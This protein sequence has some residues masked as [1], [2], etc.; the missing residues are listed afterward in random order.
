MRIIK[1]KE[2][3]LILFL[4]LIINFSTINTFPV[5]DRDE[6][7]YVQSTKQMLETGNYNS[8]KF[9]DDLRSK[10]PIGIYWLQSIS[11]NLFSFKKKT[12]YS[13][14]KLNDIWKYRFI[15]S[16]FSLFSCLAL[17]FLATKVFD[18]KTAF[19]SSLTLQCTLLFVIESHIAKTDAVLLTCSICSMLL[20]MGYYKGIFIKKF[21]YIFL[22][23]WCSL[24][25]SIMIKGPVLLLIILVTTIFIMLIKKKVKWVHATNP[26]IGFFILL[27]III[28]WFLSIPSVEQ[29]SFI[30]EGLKKDFLDK[31]I[32]AQESH[33]AFFGAHTIAILVLFFPMSLFLIPSIQKSIKGYSSENIFFLIAWIL[34]NLII[35]ELVPTKLPHYTLPLYPGLALL[36]GSNI[37]SQKSLIING[38]QIYNNLNFLLYII[39]ITVLVYVIFIAMRD[40][41]SILQ[42]YKYVAFFTYLVFLVPIFKVIRI[43]KVRS[44]YYQ[45]FLGC[46]TSIFIFG[47]LLPKLD[48]IWISKEIYNIINTDNKEFKSSTIATIGYNEPSLIFLLGTKTAVLKSLK[49][50]FF[51]KNIYNYIIV[52]KKYLPD[53]IKIIKNSKY[54]YF[55]L[56]ELKGFNM[57]KGKW[58]NTSIFKLREE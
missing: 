32:G 9:K 39:I 23:F 35:L 30:S 50:D 29:S 37:A 16:L 51:E 8:I 45:V 49:E 6:A 10:K 11:V 27:L 44:F 26:L 18:R 24:G 54:K 42:D 7:R 57:A 58:V 14:K 4:S 21:D 40:Y 56:N 5:L 17:F 28:P 13:D 15:S 55:L 53:F 1:Y 22:A 33:G 25:F 48:R 41:S 38:K 2:L 34:P 3:I 31:M 52:E 20:L 19:Y 36:V 12:D 47:F 43:N 46:I